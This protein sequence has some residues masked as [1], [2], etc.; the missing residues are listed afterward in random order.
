MQ[1]NGDICG[2]SAPNVQHHSTRGLRVRFRLIQH[3]DVNNETKRVIPSG[4]LSCQQDVL[5]MSH[6]G[7]PSRC[8]AAPNAR[9]SKQACC[10]SLASDGGTMGEELRTP[11]RG[12]LPVAS[13]P[14]STNHNPFLLPSAL[15]QQ[16]RIPSPPLHLHSRSSSWLLL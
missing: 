15:H 4:M 5:F 10:V 11:P 7:K 12:E 16:P 14:R 2:N 6:V 3:G 8:C 1:N 9:K 13:S